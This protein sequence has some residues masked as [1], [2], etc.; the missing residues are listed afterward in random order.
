M[1]DVVTII[2]EQ[3]P[4]PGGTTTIV[5]VQSQPDQGTPGPPPPGAGPFLQI[6]EN[7]ADVADATEA[8][9]N[10]GIS[11]E[12]T[13]LETTAYF[14]AA[15][16]QE[17]SEQIEELVKPQAFIEDAQAAMTLT[18]HFFGGS[19]TDID[20]SFTA[21]DL[22]DSS[23]GTADGTIAQVN[24]SVLNAEGT[25]LPTIRN[26]FADLT[27]QH[28][29]LKA[30]VEALRDSINAGFATIGELGWWS[31]T[32][33]SGLVV[34]AS[35]SESSSSGRLTLSTGAV[36]ASGSAMVVLGHDAYGISGAPVFRYSFR[37]RVT[38]LSAV[39]E[40]FTVFV[41]L[42]NRFASTSA[43][44]NQGFWFVLPTS[45]TNSGRWRCLYGDGTTTTTFNTTGAPDPGDPEADKY[46]TLT[47]EC[48]GGGTV[49]YYIDNELTFTGYDTTSTPFPVAG[50]HEM[51]PMVC[52]V[53]ATG[54]TARTVTVDS[55]A[56]RLEPGTQA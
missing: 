8:R 32:A 46:V 52:I 40:Q 37:I 11:A 30:D 27:D 48:D 29:K 6:D 22:T 53:K 16:L 13:P 4:Q 50:S 9:M 14:S 55:F 49:R 31:R 10:L 34:V 19:V 28:N 42:N 51:T 47:C 56:M 43:T 20:P 25:A 39:G 18:E 5:V 12:N 45:T 17:F 26:N 23:G 21:G 41:G 54:T 36:S 7:L 44:L 24:S 33:N 1:A 35:G 15:N 3:P 2:E 38:T